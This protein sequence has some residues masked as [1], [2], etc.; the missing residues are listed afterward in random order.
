M[1]FGRQLKNLCKTAENEIIL[2]APF[3][4][5]INLQRTVRVD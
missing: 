4:K 2:V 3:I 1:N 5:K